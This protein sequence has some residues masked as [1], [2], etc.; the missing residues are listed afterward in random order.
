MTTPTQF[1]DVKDAQKL[2]AIVARLIATKGTNGW[3]MT[4][5]YEIDSS[6]IK[7]LLRTP[8][9]LIRPENRALAAL[10]AMSKRGESSLEAFGAAMQHEVEGFRLEAATRDA[11]CWFLLPVRLPVLARL[12]LRIRVLGVDFGIMRIESLAEYLGGPNQDMDKSTAMLLD[13]SN[14]SPMFV[15][16]ESKG[17]PIEN[18]FGELSPAFDV[19]RGIMELCFTFGSRQF[20]F[21]GWSRRGKV[22]HPKCLIC[23]RE[24]E[25]IWTLYFNS[26]DWEPRFSYS[27]PKKGKMFL[28]RV[29]DLAEI[30]SEPH[31]DA[32]IKALCADLMRL[33]A[34]AME[35][36][37][38]HGCFLALW[39]MAEAITLF[40]DGERG[41]GDRVV[42]RLSWVERL[43][44]DVPTGALNIALRGLLAKRNEAVHRG[45]HGH[46]NEDDV[47][48]LKL[49]CETALQW[50]LGSRDRFP[51]KRH[52]STWWKHCQLSE[53]DLKVVEDVCKSVRES[54]LSQGA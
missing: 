45:L 49:V 20:T 15:C 38:A 5:S 40:E 35:Q 16:V 21:G 52:V 41:N 33:Y 12:P 18:A 51:T 31:E 10:G 6:A 50:L 11:K 13:E 9:G 14:L 39:Q 29:A 22:P 7:H 25:Q 42:S 30:F 23:L 24:G 36:D 44:M 27:E 8:P 28:D 46:I 47:N 2:E 3:A 19:L 26:Q 48:L 54:R 1:W 4:E 53:V 43:L 34:Q 32:S 37:Q 17:F